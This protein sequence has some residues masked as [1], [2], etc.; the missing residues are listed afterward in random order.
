MTPSTRTGP[1]CDMKKTAAR[2]ERPFRFGFRLLLEAV[3]DPVAA[4]HALGR[5]DR[6]GRIALHVDHGELAADVPGHAVR[7]LHDRLVAVADRHPHLA[8]GA[9]EGEALE[10]R[11]DFLVRRT[12]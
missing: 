12:L 10:R 5:V 9:F 8:A 2:I 6:F 11:A 4:L 1:I 7:G 3:L